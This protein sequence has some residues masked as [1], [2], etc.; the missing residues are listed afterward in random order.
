L[1]LVTIL[2]PG[3]ASRFVGTGGGPALNSRLKRSA[4]AR[5]AARE[6]IL[7]SRSSVGQKEESLEMR[8][9]F[10]NDSEFTKARASRS[11]HSTV[12]S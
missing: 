12:S 5:F 2:P 8:T 10:R 9:N 1:S 4:R 7:P 11:A 6:S 3:W